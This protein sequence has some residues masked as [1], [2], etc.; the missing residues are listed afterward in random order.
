MSGN[1]KR[2]GSNLR[3]SDAHMIAPHEYDEP[4]EFTAEVFARAD[5]DVLARWRESGR[6]WQTRHQ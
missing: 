5:A 4:P 1:R 2:I 3:K 6:G